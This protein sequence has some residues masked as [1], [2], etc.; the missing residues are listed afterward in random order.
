LQIRYIVARMLLFVTFLGISSFAIAQKS[1]S[2]VVTDETNQTLPG[3]AVVIKGTTN[4][5]ITDLDGR[6]SLS[7]PAGMDGAT[8]QFSFVGCEPQEALVPA[9]GVLNVKLLPSVN[10]I[11]EVVAIGYGTKRKGDLTGSITSVSEKDFNGGVVSSPEQ[12][13]NGKV[14]GVQI[15]S[16]GGSPTAGSTIRI[17]GGASLTASNDPLIVLDGVPLEQGGISGSGNFLSLINPSDIESMSILKDASSTAIYGSRASNGVIIITTKKGAKDRMRINFNTTN[18]VSVKTKTANML[19]ADELVDV[20]KSTVATDGDKY[21]K[22]IGD[23]NTDWN[24]EIFQAAF[25]T[26]NN[27]SVSG[28]IANKLPVRA[29]VGYLNQNGILLTDN[30]KRYTGNVNLNPTFLND[31]LKVNVSVKASLSKNT[32]ADNAAIYGAATYNPTQPIYND[33]GYFMGYNEAYVVKDGVPSLITSAARNPLARLECKDDK[34]TV[35]RIISNVDVD[36]TFPFLKDLRAHVTG[37]MDLATGEGSVFIPEE[38]SLAYDSH[39][40]DYSWAPEK[41]KNKLFTGYLNYSKK[42]DDANFDVTAGYDY[43]YWNS[44]QDYFEY[45]NTLGEVTGSGGNSWQTHTLL[46]YYARANASLRGRY[47]VTATMRRDGT[48]RFSKDQRW[49]TF[50]SVALAWRI[51]EEDFMEG[52]QDVMNNLKLRVSYGV[53]GQ[54][55]V[56]TNYGYLPIYSITQENS[57]QYYLW[58][59]KYIPI[60]K[61][62]RYA[63]N[64]KWETTKSWNFG[65]DYA[66]LNDKITGSVEYYTR[67]T[68]DLISEVPAAAG[69]NFSSSIVTNVGNVESKGIEMSVACNVINTKDLG[70]DMS[71]NATWESNEVTNLSINKGGDVVNNPA[72]YAES[73][74]VEYLTEGQKPYAFWL[75]H[76]VY[77]ADGHPL[78]GAYADLDGDGTPDKYYAHSPA[79]DWMFAYSLSLRYQKFTLSTSLRANV[80]N[81]VYNCIAAKMGALHTLMWGDT[82]GQINNI[83]ASYLD[84][85]FV[86][87]QYESDYYLENASFLKMDN[88]SLSYDF[89]KITKWA[90]LNASFMVQNVFTVTKYSGIDPEI[91]GGIEDTF[92]PR[93]RTFS[94]SLGFQF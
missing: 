11:D 4:G 8:L 14:A 15:T 94:L 59:G 20:V 7:I 50:P 55:N 49:G 75:Y 88:I 1:V 74:A 34:S 78:E 10:E 26:D 65:I 54:Q 53:T 62:Q 36:Y 42:F 48:S 3:V 28:T 6:Y 33:N 23:A 40:S 93:P 84:T 66:F 22:Y 86:E 37:G 45:Y 85:R 2:G 89:G 76:Q 47:M 79:P 91:S 77:D 67:K 81:Y 69:S 90:S 83:S 60:Y 57:G 63:E 58:N 16:G 29:S 32:F 82:Q 87:R 5:T 52:M 12:L 25:A 56:N 80:G 24:D 13:I 44:N 72:G 18:S 70:L 71:F 21:Q 17:R 92:Y 68:E 41:K 35:K 46:S 27:L 73:T 43:Q 30:L 61:T 31:A 39:G 38:A 51:S 9:N 64:L 19:S